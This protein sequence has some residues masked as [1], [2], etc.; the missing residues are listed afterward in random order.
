MLAVG[1]VAAG[2]MGG[3]DTEPTLVLPTP[4]LIATATAH[5]A[6]PARAQAAEGALDDE[7]ARLRKLA[8]VPA[9]APAQADVRV[10]LSTQASQAEVPELWEGPGLV[11]VKVTVYGC[12]ISEELRASGFQGGYCGAMANGEVVW[13]GAAACGSAFPLGLAFRLRGD[14]TG[15]T[16]TCTDR[17]RLQD[18]QVDVFFAEVGAGLAWLDQVGT[19]SQI[20]ILR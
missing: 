13:E 18:Y 4:G 7:V 8:Q 10:V 15:R 20:E 1:A 6:A 17:G 16:Y 19:R 3:D 12:R 2:C 14:P 9:P 11:E 5:P